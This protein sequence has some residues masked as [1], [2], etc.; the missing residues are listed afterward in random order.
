MKTYKR[1]LL[2]M[3]AT[4]NVRVPMRNRYLFSVLITASIAATLSMAQA[5][6]PDATLEEQL[7]SHYTLT[8]LT[9]DNAGIATL[10]TILTLRRGGFSAGA[11]SNRLP[12]RNT[13]K[14]GQI[15]SEIPGA[16]K[17][18]AICSSIPWANRV[19][20]AGSFREFMTGESLYVTK[21][22]VDRSKDTIV[23]TLVSDAYPNTGCYKGFFSNTPRA[24]SRQRICLKSSP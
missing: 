1:K 3:G 10:G 13:Y 6:V 11:A 22:N 17:N 18:C 16:L 23:F 7:Q 20:S 2:V 21:I 14:D 9:A 8:S 24:C 19:G 15:R 4:T 5:Q 12:T